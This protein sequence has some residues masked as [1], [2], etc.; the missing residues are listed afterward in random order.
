MGQSRS[1]SL[2]IIPLPKGAVLL[3]GIT[4]RIPISDRPDII[5]LISTLYARPK[6]ETA[7]ISI[8]CVP[9]KSR[10]LSAN[11]QQLIN[12]TTRDS[13]EQNDDDD[14]EEEEAEEN[15][16]YRDAG[17]LFAYGTAARITGVQGRRSDLTLTI[18]GG[19]RFKIERIVK[20]K[21]FLEAAVTYAKADAVETKDPETQE[22][23]ERL[24]QVSRTLLL[25]VQASSL[26]SPSITTA[27]LPPLITRRLQLFIA[28]KEIAEAGALA[29]FLTNVVEA[30]PEEKLRVFN[31]DSTKAGGGYERS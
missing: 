14:E 11:G 19:A 16:D 27:H 23:F 10:L 18:D 9:L 29:D 17:N 5:S 26:L 24:K 20:T 12:E 8:G 21:P 15:I 3:P 1:Q 22:L 6:L 28:R 7:S 31:D 30:T 13:Q 4:L 2:P 25:L